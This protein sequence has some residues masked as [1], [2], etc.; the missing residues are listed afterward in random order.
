MAATTSN[1][2][3]HVP[4]GNLGPR[5][6]HRMCIRTALNFLPQIWD[7]GDLPYHIVEP[8]IRRI[9]DAEQLHSIESNSPQIAAEVKKMSENWQALVEKDFLKRDIKKYEQ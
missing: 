1:S 4:P 9:T 3:L 2:E 5:S 6:L 8:L 7:I